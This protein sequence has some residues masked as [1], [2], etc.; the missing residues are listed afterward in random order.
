MIVKEYGCQIILVSH[1]PL[2]L[3]K[4]VSNNEYVNLISIDEQYSNE[5][6][7]KLRNIEF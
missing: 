2:V 5:V 6:L 7:T 3:S 1:N 4:T